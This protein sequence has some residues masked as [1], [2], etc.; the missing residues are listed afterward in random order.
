MG[1]KELQGMPQGND[2]LTELYE[3]RVAEKIGS[4]IE[5]T[6]RKR[7]TWLG[8]IAIFLTGGGATLLA[9]RVLSDARFQAKQAEKINKKSEILLDEISKSTAEVQRTIDRVNTLE[10]KASELSERLK[11]GL[12]VLADELD[13]QTSERFERDKVDLGPERQ[14]RVD[15]ILDM[16]SKLSS[17]KAIDLITNPPVMD[18][19]ADQLVQLRDPNNKRFTE[20]DVA[21]QLL[22]MRAV[23]S[24]RIGG[25]FDAWKA[26]LKAQ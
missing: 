9:D 16:I 2:E 15:E 17:Q 3:R 12:K 10:A 18:A 8:F 13:R 7:Y 5:T 6:L 23:L 24:K 20:G 25:N 4:R 11:K 14:K 1:E 21:R 19:K 22:K 26:A